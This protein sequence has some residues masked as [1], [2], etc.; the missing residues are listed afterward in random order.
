MT[1]GVVATRQAEAGGA[2][3]AYDEHG[4]G[5]PALLFLTGWC[6]NRERWRSVADRL[7]LR[8]RVLL[9]EWRGH[10]DSRPAPG[11]FGLEEMVADAL[12]V[13]D[14]AGAETFVPCAASH[15]GFVAIELRRRFPE[16]VPRLVHCD[17]YVVPPP[18]PYRA[19]LRRLTDPEGWPEARDRLFEI[20]RGGT[21]LGDVESALGVMNEHD[22]E[23]WMRSG[24]E[25]AAGYA[26]IGSPVEAWAALDPPL[27][28]LHVYGQPRDPAF[29][30]AQRTFAAT[31]PWFTVRQ[32][33][34]VT[35][36]AMIETPGEVA[37]AIESF[38]AEAQAS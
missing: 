34:G 24:R 7:A 35:H 32:T 3:L 6:S 22:A 5:E 11:D 10:G 25:I 28:V 21:G 13:A 14:A 33:P 36:F 37:A 17:W 15:S 26:R 23:M 27:P 38:L 16:R 19:V 1:G 9:T 4:T 31:H 2:R 12:A 20:W 30:E 18:P 8:R 29:L